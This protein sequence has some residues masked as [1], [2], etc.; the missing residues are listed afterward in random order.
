MGRR[1]DHSRDE[2]RA[3]ALAAAAERVNRHGLAGLSAR[4]VAAD[5]GYTVGTLYLVFRNIDALI[6]E[7]NAQTLER[8]ARQLDRQT[9]RCRKPQT[10]LYALA[11]G[12]IQFASESSNLWLC[13]FEHRL[14]D[15]EP[16]PAWFTEKVNALFL[17]VEHNLRALATR[18][19]AQVQ[20]AA[21]ALWGGVHG[22][23][24]L[25]LNGKLAVTGEVNV[26][27]LVDSL[28]KNYLVGYVQK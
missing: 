6:L 24:A 7:L 11:H 23:C 9:Q 10:C 12:Y 5:I 21:R 2:I 16:V 17:K 22:I 3:M 4:K 13:V 18:S 8:L 14:A 20:L 15:D 26:K 19:D 27:A 28:I 25:G 1:S